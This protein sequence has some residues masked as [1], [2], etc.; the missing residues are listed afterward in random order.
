MLYQDGLSLTKIEAVKPGRS[1]VLLCL[2]SFSP[3]S[4]KRTALRPNSCLLLLTTAGLT[5][6]T[7]PWSSTRPVE[8]AGIA[9]VC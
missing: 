6:L 8:F 7:S 9:W 3:A 4:G 1:E 5:S 2:R